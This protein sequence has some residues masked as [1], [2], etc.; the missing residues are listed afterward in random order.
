MKGLILALLK[1]RVG[2]EIIRILFL[3]LI[4]WFA[5]NGIVLYK[6]HEKEIPGGGIDVNYAPIT[7]KETEAEID[8]YIKLKK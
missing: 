4:Q 2:K 3:E 6:R 1:S 8:L 7:T 5:E